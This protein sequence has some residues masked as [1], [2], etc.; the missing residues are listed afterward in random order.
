MF[1]QNRFFAFFILAATLWIVGQPVAYGQATESSEYNLDRFLV[2]V[3]WR[4]G[5]EIQL[6]FEAAEQARIAA[7]EAEKTASEQ[8]LAAQTRI[9]QKKKEIS[10]N[11][12]ARKIAKKDKNDSQ[13]VVLE[14]EGKAL[15]REKNLLEERESL[16]D[17]EIKLAKMRGDLAV[18]MK[19]AYDMERQL[20][21]KRMDQAGVNISGLESARAARVIYDLEKETLEAQKKVADKQSEVADSAKKVVA[22]Q[23]KILEAQRAIIGGK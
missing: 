2:L 22:S 7:S 6:D 15:E 16:R 23:L 8:K 10:S 5:E 19:Q 3:P 13:A 12:D 14:T 18:L 21:A 17:A 11:K 1:K 20:A 4:H 9:A